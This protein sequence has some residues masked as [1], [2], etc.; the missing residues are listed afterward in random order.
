MCG[1]ILY[2]LDKLIY[3]DDFM[4]NE[5]GIRELPQFLYHY[6]S[7]ESLIKIIETNS[8]KF[9]RLDRVNDPN[10]ALSSKL[11][12]SNTL[13]FVSCWSSDVEESIPMWN[14]Y[15][16]NFK[17]VR[18]KL[19]T[20]MFK[21][22]H[23]PNC[24]EKGGFYINYDGSVLIEREIPYSLVISKIIGPN[25]I[26]YIDNKEKLKSR[27]LYDYENHVYVNLYDLGMLKNTYWD[28]EQEWR[29]KIIGLVDEFYFPK[30]NLT[31]EILDLEK[32]SRKAK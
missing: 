21:G 3:T 22:R 23:T 15:G 11:S 19:T 25:K 1:G 10:E 2:N 12:Y 26:A 28:Y 7:V 31:K 8:I 29:F 9:N 17:G 13:V 24:F 30:D 27:C 32:K 14:M 4:W 5:L 20:N 18:I 16:N 6:T